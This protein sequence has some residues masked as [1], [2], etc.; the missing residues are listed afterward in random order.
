MNRAEFLKQVAEARLLP[1][2]LFLGEEQ[3]FHE[4]LFAA[5]SARLV[6]PADLP[7]NLIRL[8]AAETTPENLLNN[9]E[10]PPF[11]GG[12]RLIRLEK[13]EESAHGVDEALLKGFSRLPDGVYLFVS[14]AKLDGRKKVHQELTKHLNVVDCSGLKANELPL[15]L[16]QRAEQMG[17]KLPTHQLR[18]IGERLGPNLL[19]IRTELEKLRTFLGDRPAPSD[20]ELEALIPGEPEPDIFGLIDAVAQRDP[21]L[22]LPRLEEL[23]D[24]GENETKLLATLSRQFRNITAA[25]T[26]RSSGVNAKALAGMLGIN[27]YVAEKSFAQAARFGLA[28]LAWIAE[29]LVTADYRMKSGQREPRLE[30]ELAVAEICSSR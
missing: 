22:G 25:Q 18:R 26:A 13:L 9:L 24:A 29:R 16:K 14:A 8:P 11:F 1:A 19:R 27:P 23:L 12:A 5:A 21:R 6:A 28:E 30:L 2:Y 10:T 15:W 4:E 17:L 7:F 3:L 20:A